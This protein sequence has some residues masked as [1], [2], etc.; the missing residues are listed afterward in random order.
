VEDFGQ[1]RPARGRSA[2]V[3]ERLQ[4]TRVDQVPRPAIRLNRHLGPYS[5]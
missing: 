1:M 2:R 5:V 3:G 4:R